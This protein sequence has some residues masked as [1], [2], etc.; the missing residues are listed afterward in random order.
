MV[1]RVL[2][3]QSITLPRAIAELQGG[4]K[5]LRGVEEKTTLAPLEPLGEVVAD[6]RPLFHWRSVQGAKNYLIVI[7]DSQLHRVDASPALQG[8]EWR[9]DLPLQR[10]M[11]YQWVVEAS[12]DN[13]ATMIAPT[14]AHAEAKFKV[15]QQTA[16]EQF[17][18]FREAHANSHLVLGILCAQAGML[19]L[20]EREW[21]Q[22]AAGNPDYDLAQKL[23]RSVEEIRE[24]RDSNR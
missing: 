9:P 10:G 2:E 15:L 22:I 21:R 3:Q 17:N 23:M 1:L 14:P 18:R 4:G 12:M 16:A 6:D 24:P 5:T 13:G 7:L 20:A 11:V 19:S 8:T